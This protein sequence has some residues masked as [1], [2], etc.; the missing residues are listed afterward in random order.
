M[1]GII[2]S[3]ATSELAYSPPVKIQ[4]LSISK[5]AMSAIFQKSQFTVLWSCTQTESCVISYGHYIECISSTPCHY[6]EIFK[7]PSVEELVFRSCFVDLALTSWL[8]CRYNN[9]WLSH[10]AIL[11][12]IHWGSHQ[13]FIATYQ[14]RRSMLCPDQHPQASKIVERSSTDTW[15]FINRS[16]YN[17]CRD[18]S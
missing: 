1:N 15:Q 11:C 18:V 14:N 3:L 13:L 4:G 5:L 6:L 7:A 17:N 10:R 8:V 2:S 12:K 16:A 9:G